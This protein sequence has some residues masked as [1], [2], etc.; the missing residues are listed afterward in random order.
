[1][2]IKYA[3]SDTGYIIAVLIRAVHLLI[4]AHNHDPATHAAHLR[5]LLLLQL[6][7]LA[8]A[9]HRHNRSRRLLVRRMHLRLLLLLWI[10]DLSLN[11]LLMLNRLSCE[12]ALVIGVIIVH[13][14]KLSLLGRRGRRGRRGRVEVVHDYSL[15]RV[16]VLMV[17]V[18]AL[19][20]HGVHLN[21]MGLRL[22]RLSRLLLYV[23][24]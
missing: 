22:R 17:V 21:L 9:V 11:K 23:R 18:V 24:V 13:V 19:A 15:L 4:L 5:L 8:K 2:R 16:H 12:H 3:L 14:Y 6:L 10:H 20:V 1:M 7:L